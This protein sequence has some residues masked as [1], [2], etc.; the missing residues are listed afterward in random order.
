MDCHALDIGGY[1][2]S[3]GVKG[4]IGMSFSKTER[5]P[6]LSQCWQTFQT[7]VT[8][9]IITTRGMRRP[10]EASHSSTQ[11]NHSL[12]DMWRNTVSVVPL[13]F[14]KFS[15]TVWL[16]W[17]PKILSSSPEKIHIVLQLTKVK[18]AESR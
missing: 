5:K 3:P 15:K 11:A 10:E 16:S 17:P 13:W 9:Y 7:Y 18:P 14:H 12:W 8:G 1:L 6:S 2:I 4:F